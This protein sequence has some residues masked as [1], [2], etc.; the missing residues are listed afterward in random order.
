M[1]SEEEGS[2]LGS[3]ILG[4]TGTAATKTAGFVAAAGAGAARR[5]GSYAAENAL[6]FGNLFIA[7][8]I[9]INFLV[10]RYIPFAGFDF[11][12]YGNFTSFSALTQNWVNLYFIFKGP[13]IAVSF[14]IAFVALE[15]R[16]RFGLRTIF[17][18]TAFYSIMLIPALYRGYFQI[19]GLDFLFFIFFMLELYKNPSR[20][21][22]TGMVMFWVLF[23]ALAGISY[24]TSNKGA[25]W[26]LSL[27][28][29]FY[30]VQGR[31][32]GQQ[33][34]SYRNAFI[35]LILFDFIFV[36]FLNLLPQPGNFTWTVVPVLT[37][38]VS[39]IVQAYEP[40]FFS[41]FIVVVIIVGLVGLMGW[42]AFKSVE[43]SSGKVG[44]VEPG[45]DVV[46]SRLE[47]LKFW[48]WPDMLSNY[49]QSQV[50]I[51]SGSTYAGQVD[52]NAK[53]KLGV[54]LED[55]NDNP[56]D[57][58]VGEKIVID[59]TIS[60][61]NFAA[62]DDADY[63]ELT[64]AITCGAITKERNGTNVTGTILP[65]SS[66]IVENY[67]VQNIQCDFEDG[68][69]KGTYDIV[70]EVTFNFQT[71]AYLKRYF[72]AKSVMDSQRRKQLIKEDADILKVNK[73]D[74]T[75]PI[76]QNSVGPVQINAI[77]RIPVVIK[78]SNENEVQYLF[79]VKLENK[80][81]GKIKEIKNIQFYLPDGMELQE[82]KCNP[83]AMASY[84]SNDP[85]FENYNLIQLL[86]LAEPSPRLMNIETSMEETC[87]TMIRPGSA[88]RILSP[89]DVTTRYIGMAAE[90]DY[91]LEGKHSIAVRTP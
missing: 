4:G 81:D 73:I 30:V 40:N 28:T 89:G 53:K 13:L 62:A 11:S 87:W 10:D 14:L 52:Q 70:I 38:G 12:R 88:A 48:K 23:Y 20:E 19:A 59:A 2:S 82:G 50:A 61:Q 72:V 27:I 15:A 47:I 45:A 17:I 41:K 63:K 74:D 16:G 54:Y 58:F 75:D 8:A 34:P 55:I 77:D 9:L 51:A 42:A 39:M 64:M 43:A 33:N 69:P 76:S 1:A 46:N 78:V 68:L 56:K 67:D 18:F 6:N 25:L 66:F 24:T 32:Y 90:Y 21:E 35:M 36:Y 57:F 83:F 65:S 86:P 84:F 7:G 79:G 5:V 60:A 71:H 91:L 29:L 31:S 44:T 26:H 37:L 85:R 22:Y 3:K 80:W 49:T